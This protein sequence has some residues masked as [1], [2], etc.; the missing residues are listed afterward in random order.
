TYIGNY[1]TSLEMVGATLTV[2]ALD[3]ELKRLLDVDV[4]CPARL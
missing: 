1:F 2:M 3:A 4:D